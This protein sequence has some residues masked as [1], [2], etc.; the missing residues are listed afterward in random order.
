LQVSTNIGEAAVWSSVN[1]S[2]D[3]KNHRFEFIVSAGMVDR[4]F[5]RISQ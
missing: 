2:P 5:Y 3:L 4:Q 1:A